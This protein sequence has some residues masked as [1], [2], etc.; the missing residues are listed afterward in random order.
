MNPILL[1]QLSTFI[2]VFSLG[3]FI[4]YKN[5]RSQINRFFCIF[6]LGTAIWNLSLF[7]V[8]SEIGQPLLWGRLAFSFGSFMAMGLFLFSASFPWP[9]R[10]INLQKIAL[11]ALGILF[12]IIPA[13]DLMIKSVKPV[14]RT[15]ISGEL[16]NVYF[17]FLI[18]YFGFLIA[19]FVKLILKHKKSEGIQS[20]QLKYVILGV[21]SFFIPVFITQLILPILGIFQYNNLGPLFSLPMIALIGYAIVRHRLM[22]I[23]VIVQRGL[24]YTM[25]LAL[26][27]GVYLSLI[28]FLGYFF[29]KAANLTVFLSAG[30]T[31]MIGIFGVPVIERYFRRITDPIFFKDTYDYAT[32]LHELSEILNKHINSDAIISESIRKL[33]KIFK[34]NLIDFVLTREGALSHSP[35]EHDEEKITQPIILGLG[36][37]VLEKLS[38]GRSCREMYILK[39]TYDCLKHLRNRRQ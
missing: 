23:R 24:I 35:G 19:S 39:K 9:D 34:T 7:L 18:Y 14:N 8:I 36:K 21:I 37:R 17:V 16:T 13:T 28:N 11:Y 20:T 25:L 22:D 15:Y 5:P 3:I 26:T 29:Q 4:L 30:I 12:F 31:T 1:I 10:R 32:A 27:I 6:A 33:G 38:L 2:L